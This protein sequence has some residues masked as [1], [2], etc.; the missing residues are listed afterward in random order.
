MKQPVV[1][2]ATITLKIFNLNGEPALLI[3]PQGE[4]FDDPVLKSQLMLATAE[5]LRDYALRMNHDPTCK[6]VLEAA[7]P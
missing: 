3:D 1:T 7:L 2:Q 5:N 6:A 4:L